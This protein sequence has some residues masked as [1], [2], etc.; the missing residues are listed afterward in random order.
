[1][2]IKIYLSQNCCVSIIVLTFNINMLNVFKSH[3]IKSYVSETSIFKAS[4][5]V[6]YLINDCESTNF[7]LIDE[8]IIQVIAALQSTM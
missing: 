1:M 5:L 4:C 6:F 3:K 7:L 2:P 8:S